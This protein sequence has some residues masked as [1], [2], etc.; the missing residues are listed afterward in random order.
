MPP[1]SNDLKALNNFTFLCDLRKAMLHSLIKG[2][3]VH[4]EAVSF[5]E[6]DHTAVADG[7]SKVINS[8]G[9]VVG[10][11]ICTDD[12]GVIGLALIRLDELRS[13]SQL[14]SVLL[15]GEE[16]DTSEIETDA[17]LTGVQIYPFR[18]DWWP[19]LDPVTGKKVIED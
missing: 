17:D 14:H 19:D 16:S 15:S 4:P 6:F 3:G 2:G 1:A 9:K 13:S 10:D 18:P 5:D 11:I 8:L 7:K 12:I